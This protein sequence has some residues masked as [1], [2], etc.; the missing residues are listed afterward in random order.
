MDLLISLAKHIPDSQCMVLLCQ[1]IDDLSS[2]SFSEE[3]KNYIQNSFD[4]D[5]KSVTINRYNQFVFVQKTD[6]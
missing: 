4:K 2:F 1:S 3:E 5:N 6:E